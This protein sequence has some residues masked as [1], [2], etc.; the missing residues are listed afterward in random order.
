MKFAQPLWLLIGVIACA[1]LL[2]RYRRFDRQQATQLT[3]FIAPRLAE[4]LTRSFS[5]QR[6]RLKRIYTEID[7]EEKTTHTMKKFQQSHELFTW[8]VVPAFAVLCTSLGLQ[9]TRF[10]RLPA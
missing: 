2:W 3:K 7:R 10:R 9:Q 8:A 6:R 4:Q 5:P 1:A